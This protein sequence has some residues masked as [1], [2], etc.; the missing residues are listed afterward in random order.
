[1]HFERANSQNV[2]VFSLSTYTSVTQ[3]QNIFHLIYNNNSP[4]IEIWFKKIPT[5]SKKEK[6]YPFAITVNYHFFKN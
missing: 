1:M 4:F 2:N 5:K 3:Q 6:Q